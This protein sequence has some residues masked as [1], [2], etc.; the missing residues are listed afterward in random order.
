[1]HL[2]LG[3][4]LTVCSTV[5]AIS[6]YGMQYLY[7]ALLLSVGRYC[8]SG[9][10][11]SSVITLHPMLSK[12]LLR[13]VPIVRIPLVHEVSLEVRRRTL[14]SCRAYCSRAVGPMHSAGPGPGLALL[15]ILRRSTCKNRIRG[16]LLCPSHCRKSCS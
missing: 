8:N 5:S 11:C 7:H 15:R 1:M 4:Y 16:K 9:A 3:T 12:Y 6:S 14:T 2:V 13:R 10:S